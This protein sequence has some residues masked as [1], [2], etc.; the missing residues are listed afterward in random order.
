[1]F[2]FEVLGEE[3]TLT[4]IY[5]IFIG[6]GVIGLILSAYRW[7]ASIPILMILGGYAAMM[8]GE[9][10]D[11]FL[12]RDIMREDPNYISLVT[13]AIIV[14]LMLPL[15]GIVYNLARRFNVFK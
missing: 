9:F 1:M 2:L 10:N 14:G 6:F 11:P 7:W 13:L 4:V 15:L 5:S 3:P 8:F 12:Y